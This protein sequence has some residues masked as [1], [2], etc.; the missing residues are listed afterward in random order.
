MK[1]NNLKTREQGEPNQF[2]IETEDGRDW[3][4]SVQFNGHFTV[5]Q[6]REMISKMV[7]AIEYPSETFLLSCHPEQ[8]EAAKEY[9]TGLGLG[10]NISESDQGVTITLPPQRPGMSFKIIN[11][12]DK[13]IVITPNPLSTINTNPDE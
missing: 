8:K 3:I 9:L 13:E 4:A 10:C 2:M 5:W 1:I 11:N 7:F 12:S 6:Q